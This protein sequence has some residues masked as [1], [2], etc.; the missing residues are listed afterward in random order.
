MLQRIKMPKPIAYD[1]AKYHI[2]TVKQL[3][4]PVQHA[5]HHTTFF[6]SWLIKKN[7]LSEEFAELSKEIISKYSS[8]T[9]TINQVY[10]FFDT[11]LSN[12]IFRAGLKT[13]LYS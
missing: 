10:E 8:G 7:M 4:L 5:Y 2:P 12:D 6:L 11:C 3:G 13:C 1:K 9:I